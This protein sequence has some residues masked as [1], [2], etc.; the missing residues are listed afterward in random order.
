MPP[1]P[2]S[3]RSHRSMRLLSNGRYTVMLDATA[4]G[5]SQWNTLAVTR[6]REVATPDGWGAHLLLGGLTQPSGC[7][8]A[9]RCAS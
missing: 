7:M 5:F 9:R 2:T 6:W 8:L 3:P 4:T 1:Q